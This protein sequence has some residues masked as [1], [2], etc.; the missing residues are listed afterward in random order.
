MPEECD[1]ERAWLAKF[2]GSL[3]EIAGEDIRKE[4][5]RESEELSAHSSR[6]EVID[7]CRS[8]AGVFCDF[9]MKPC[10]STIEGATHLPGALH[11]T[12]RGYRLRSHR[13]Q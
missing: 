9:L 4:V 11:L 5:M 13:G 12:G 8:F 3:D 10:N 2:S 1:F 7:S 6:R